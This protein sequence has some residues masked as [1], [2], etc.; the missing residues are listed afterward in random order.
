M[1]SFGNQAFATDPSRHIEGQ[2]IVAKPE[3]GFYLE[4]FAEFGQSNPTDGDSPRPSYGFGLNL[5][6][7]QASNI[8]TRLTPS[9]EIFSKALNS[10]NRE[11]IIPIG[12]LFK[13][14][15][16][17][18]IGNNLYAGPAIGLGMGLA[19][20]EQ[21]KADISYESTSQIPLQTITGQFLVDFV[22]SSGLSFRTGLKASHYLMSVDE[23]EFNSTKVKV[24]E[25]VHFNSIEF[26]FGFRLKFSS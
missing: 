12:A 15:Y 18:R 5:G 17:Y 24:D 16:A 6:W 23:L 20:Y 7:I 2:T 13:I 21:T 11:V 9:F 25:S 14:A 10:A 1:F 4:P 3:T 19:S 8:W 26:L 22:A